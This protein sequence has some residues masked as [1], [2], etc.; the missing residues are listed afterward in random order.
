MSFV[1]VKKEYLKES[2]IFSIQILGD[3]KIDIISLNIPKISKTY[4]MVKTYG[5]IKS[6]IICPCCC[7]SFAGNNIDKATR[8]I[9]ILIG[10]KEFSID[11]LLEVAFEIHKKSESANDIEFIICY[12]DQKN[13]MHIYCIKN[14]EMERDVYVA[15]IGTQAALK[16]LQKETQN[17]LEVFSAFRNV[18]LG[19]KVNCVGG[20]V[21]YV[22][23]DYEEKSFKYQ[24][25]LISDICRGQTYNTG[26]TIK[27][28]GTK[29]EGAFQMSVSGGMEEVFYQFEENYKKPLPCHL[30]HSYEKLL[31]P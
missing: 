18:V 29:E 10:K 3:T 4:K 22:N 25:Y 14:G 20:L 30:T 21:S 13:E 9:D 16:E 7:I 2:G 1:Y 28:I 8:L 12:V 26:D 23:Y 19:G 15:W 31:L 27:I 11:Y 6:L 5:I 24:D 17:G